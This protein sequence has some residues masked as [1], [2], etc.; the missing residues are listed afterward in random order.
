MQATV[1]NQIRKGPAQL[2][3][4]PKVRRV[5]DAWFDEQSQNLVILSAEETEVRSFFGVEGPLLRAGVVGIGSVDSVT[6]SLCEAVLPL[7]MTEGCP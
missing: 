2:S 4:E 1:P 5:K 3:P 6:P 7:R